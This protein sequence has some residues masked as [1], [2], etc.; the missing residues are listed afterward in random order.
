MPIYKSRYQHVKVYRPSG[1]KYEHGRGKTIKQAVQN[2]TERFQM[3][4]GY[5]PRK[6]DT[7]IEVV[8]GTFTWAAT[9][10][11]VIDKSNGEDNAE[12]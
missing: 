4:F 12:T 10:H 5:L 6:E 3:E 2:A 8:G 9:F 7:V 11:E 1:T